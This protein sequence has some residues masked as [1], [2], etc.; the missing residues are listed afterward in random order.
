M[1]DVIAAIYARTSTTE[2]NGAAD[3]AKSVTRQVEHAKAYAAKKGWTVAAAHVYSDDGI[4]GAEFSK[5]PGFVRMLNALG[6]RAPFAT[7]VVSE[8]S[9]LG[10]EQLE[11][12]YALKQLSQAGVA[13]WS[14]LEDREVLLDTPTDKFLMSAM[15]FAAEVEREKGRQR[16]SD[17]MTRKARQGY[18]TGGRCFGYDNVE[19]LGPDGR[20]AHVERRINDAE[21][22]IVREI[23]TRCAAGEGVKAIAKTL[24]ARGVP[25]PHPCRPGGPRGWSSSSVHGALYRRTYLGEIRYSMTRRRDRWGQLA[26]QRR[27]ESEHV[28][29]AQPAW[30]IVDDT[31][32]AAAHKRLADSRATYLRSASGQLWGRQASGI[33]SRYLLSGLTRCAV[34]GGSLVA[35]VTAQ[36]RRRWRYDICN[37]YSH[38]GRSVCANALPLP[39]DAA[40]ATVLDKR[41]L[42]ARSRSR[43]GRDRRRA[44]R[45][46]PVG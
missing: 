14:Y 7:L 46:A 20:R 28:V 8:L 5:R 37:T 16:V 40:D 22:A 2:Q 31:L 24:N 12:G 9:R 19:V 26:F 34:C 25:T 39:M 33:A 32:W 45:T 27:A 30:R 4:S 29:V 1:W 21:A 17:A 36:G 18:V 43:R 3:E 6:P 35:H 13:V 15:S 41:R 23:F 11:T 38:R 10:R 44:R 42:R